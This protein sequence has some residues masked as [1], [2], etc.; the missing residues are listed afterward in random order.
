MLTYC[1]I[2][3]KVNI[4]PIQLKSRMNKQEFERIFNNLTERRKNI[5]QKIL[6]GDTDTDIAKAMSITEGSV[7][8]YVER[9]CID[10]LSYVHDQNY[11]HRD[12]NPSNIMLKPDG[13]LVLI[14]FGIVKEFIQ[15]TQ[16]QTIPTTIV[17]TPGYN[18]P[19]QQ[20][21]NVGYTSDFFS[22]G[23]TFLHLLTGI[24]P[25]YDNFPRD[26]R[27]KL[28]WQDKAPE[29]SEEFKNL[30]DYLM[31]PNQKN[32]PQNTKEILRLI[33]KNKDGKQP[34]F[35]PLFVF[36]SLALNFVF[37]TLL[38]TELPPG[39]KVLFFVVLCVISGFLVVPWIKYYLL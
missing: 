16:K 27:G 21:G 37:L 31:E 17:G 32:R 28:L 36:S 5:L 38:A 1:K 4:Q 23:R 11:L 29:I 30:I 2:V 20:E 15:K 13:Q 3:T 34:E 8:K 39:L 6:S 33:P 35:R 9:I 18:S 12:I 25:G 10:I 14:D 26:A 22:L 7:R 24:F 19:E